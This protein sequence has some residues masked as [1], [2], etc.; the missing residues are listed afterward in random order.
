MLEIVKRNLQ[1]Y[2]SSSSSTS[3]VI[4]LENE[5]VRVFVSS[6]IDL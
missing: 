1:G 6:R 5:E 3:S 4:V 2:I